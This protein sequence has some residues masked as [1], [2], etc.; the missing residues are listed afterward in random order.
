MR[1]A[2]AVVVVMMMT[3]RLSE[4]EGDE[5]DTAA[6]IRV[7]RPTDAENERRTFLPSERMGE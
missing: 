3:G 4:G 7:R 5:V 1:G 6:A 2:D